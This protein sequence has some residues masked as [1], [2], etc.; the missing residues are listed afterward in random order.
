MDWN[1]YTTWVTS[2][3]IQSLI[4]ATVGSLL[5]ILFDFVFGGIA[6][7]LARNS[8][9]SLDD[10]LI[11]AGR[12]PAKFTIIIV[13]LWMGAQH[14]HPPELALV[15]VR[16]ILGLWAIGVWG[17]ALFQGIKVLLGWLSRHQDRFHS[18][19]NRTVPILELTAKSFII[20][21]G[22]YFACL[23]WGLDVTGWLAS[24]G[25]LGVVLGFG[26]RD[27]VADLFAGLF[28]LAEAPFRQGDYL[29]LPSG[30]RGRVTR[31]GM[32]TTRMLTADEVEIIIPNSHMATSQ[33]C[34]ESGGP[35]EMERVCIP[36]SVAYGTDIDE[37]RRILVEVAA[38]VPGVVQDDTLH[39]ST[40]HFEAMA[41]SGLALLLK[42][43]ILR[44]E[45]QLSVID[46]LNTRVYK[47]LNQEGIEIPYPKQDVF[48]YKKS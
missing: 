13:S 39:R 23:A 26:A 2:P 19:N 1:D 27:T 44:P 15:A 18:I 35:R 30:K 32:R 31:I 43:W 20:A 5:G 34:N 22:L 25:V 28:I 12:P 42:V 38:E 16:G 33:I 47:R 45:L 24:A 29:L 21:I 48:L 40:V 6:S 9:T 8:S 17:A 46:Q 10:E 41:D 3:L 36:I 11:D 7:R 4:I 14:A 37:A